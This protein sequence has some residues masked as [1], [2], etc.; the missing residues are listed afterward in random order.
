M[1]FELYVDDSGSEPQSQIFFLGGLM[2][3][4]DD[5]ASFS[6]EWAAAP[7]LPPTLDYFKMSEAAALQGQFSRHNGWNERSRDDRLTLLA[8][9]ATKYARQR[10][11][12]SMRHDLFQKYL[13]SVPAVERNLAT[14]TPYVFLFTQMITIAI[15]HASRRGIQDKIDFI[16]DEQS[17]FSDEAIRLWPLYTS[18]LDASLRPDL[19]ELIGGI[20]TFKDEKKFLPIQVA[21]LYAWQARN[22]YIVNHKVK[23][24]T[25]EIPMNNILRM[26]IKIPTY[27][28]P[29]KED[30][31]NRQHQSMLQ[32]G[33][34][35]SKIF[36]ETKLIPTAA[37]H[38]ERK[39][40]RKKA[41]SLAKTPGRNSS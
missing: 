24:Q 5:W 37:N 3:S 33:A 13:M 27:H 14:D 22:Y 2:S 15:L 35:I 11:T 21:D 41:R 26:F 20:P 18:T 28:R 36:S 6:N 8:R 12:V 19:R 4:A 23:T 39:R 30:E 9:I 10:N 40:I 17:G 38:R 1:R 7:A 16:F 25:I 29:L 34:I 32:T 31:L